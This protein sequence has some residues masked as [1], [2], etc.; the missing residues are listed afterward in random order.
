MKRKIISVL[1]NTLT[2][3]KWKHTGYAVFSTLNRYVRIGVLSAIYFN[4][5]GVNTSFAQVQTDTLNTIINLN[6]VEV[7]GEK[8]SSIYSEVGRVITTISRADIESMP[9]QSVQDLLRTLSGVDVRTRGPLG[10]QADISVRGGTSDQVMILL[11]GINISD[12]QSGHH[13]LNIPI[14]LQ[15]VEKIEIIQGATAHKFGANAFNGAINFITT[16]DSDNSL[17]LNASYGEHNLYSVGA[18]VNQVYKKSS[19]LFSIQKT[20]TD[21]YIEN[22]DFDFINLYFNSNLKVKKETF[23]L[24]LGYTDKDFGANSFYSIAYPNQFENTKTI[25]SSLFVK[26]GGVIKYNSSL[27]WRRHYDRFELFRENKNSPTW[28]ANHNYHLTDVVGGNAN[29]SVKSIVGTSS[30]G[31]EVRSESVLSNVLGFAMNKPVSIP[32]VGYLFYDKYFAR[33]NSSLFFE[34]KYN[35]NRFS[36]MGA[37]LL[38]HNNQSNVGLSLFPGFDVDF[39]LLDNLKLMGS[40]N[41]SMRLP[42]FTDLFYNGPDN[43]GNQYLKPEIVTSYEFGGK[44][45]SSFFD[46]NTSLYYRVGE[47]LIDWGKMVG[48]TKYT[49][50]NI[51]LIESYGLDFS[52]TL[53]VDKI[54]NQ[55]F[56]KNLGIDYNWIFQEKEVPEN[57]QSVYVLNHLKH[58]L[59]IYSTHNLGINGLDATLNFLYRE[60][61]GGYLKSVTNKYVDYEPFWV[62]DLKLSWNYKDYLFF[63]EATN[64]FDTKYSDFSELIQPGRWLR[65]GVSYKLNY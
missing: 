40:V 32:N 64:I 21:G 5:L 34:Q 39:W 55:I 10:A 13:T 57:Y 23:S 7:K 27:Y 3:K 50:S 25:F 12:P 16:S 42:T 8:Q 14:D 53:K 63:V 19:S 35:I 38:N 22:T 30:L 20:A 44:Y 33:I 43:I 17:K 28:Y 60:R 41:K 48:E 54:F 18:A 59:N 24:Q 58:K 4:C 15:N 51:N 31:V 36:F 26:G 1:H 2:F 52:S 45:N 61:E 65:L 56:F 46:I 11:N 37:V 49:T 29:L 9:V 62:I 6:E 47:N